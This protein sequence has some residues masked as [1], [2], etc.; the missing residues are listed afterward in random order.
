MKSTILA[1]LTTLV[2]FS[3]AQPTQ[4][5]GL[6]TYELQTEKRAALTG[7]MTYYAPGEG[8]CGV[9]NTATDMIVAVAPSVYGTYAN[10]NASPACQ[11]SMTINCNGKTVT[12]AVKDRC[13]G[14][15]ANDIDVSP[16][17]FEVCGALSTGAMTVSWTMN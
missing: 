4:L 8:A 3:S 17:V 2:A 1:T 12:A 9:T 10:P 11:K 13:A 6:Q 15:G 5:H 7:K 14:C 16:A